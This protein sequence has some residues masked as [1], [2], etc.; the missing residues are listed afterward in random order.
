MEQT[1]HPGTRSAPLVEAEA[2]EAQGLEVLAE[3][4]ATEDLAEAQAQAEG[5]GLPDPVM[6]EL[7]ALGTQ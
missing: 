4:A 5:R 3:M 2:A 7:A 6:G 1:G